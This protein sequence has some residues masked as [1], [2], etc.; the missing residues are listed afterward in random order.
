MNKA[1][2]LLSGGLDSTVT[3]YDAMF[4]GYAVK[5]LTINYGQLHAKEIECARVVTR[6]LNIEHEV[7]ALTFPWKGSALLDTNIPIPEKRTINNNDVIPD[8]YV[9]SRNT[10]FLSMAFSWAE[11]AG[12]D[13]VFI[14]ANQIDYSGYPDC[15]KEYFEKLQEVF[16]VGTKAGVEGRAI[17]IVTPLL[18]LNKKESIFL[19]KK[20]QVPFRNTWSCYKGTEKPCEVCDSCILRRNGFKEA[21]I[22]DP[23]VNT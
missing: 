1:I 14:G 23:L 13:S 15:R 8:T 19:G 21:G 9:P 2:V 11:A 7:I 22:P 17:T 18:G 3:L 10:V 5:A 6:S 12:A 4:H 20:Y 16:C